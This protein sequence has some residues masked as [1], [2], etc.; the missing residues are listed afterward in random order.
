MVHT[1]P[2]SETSLVLRISLPCV[3]PSWSLEHAGSRSPGH[4]PTASRTV[5]SPRRRAALPRTH[6]FCTPRAPHTLTVE[7]GPIGAAPGLTVL[8][9]FLF[10]CDSVA[11]SYRDWSRGARWGQPTEGSDTEREGSRGAKPVAAGQPKG[12]TSDSCSRRG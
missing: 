3:S 1:T 12:L 5:Q 4:G 8:Y 11:H 7:E 9:G 2:L 10:L 6:Q